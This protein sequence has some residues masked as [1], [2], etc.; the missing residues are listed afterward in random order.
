M[1]EKTVQMYQFVNKLDS[2]CQKHYVY[3]TKHPDMTSSV[4]F[5]RLDV[6]SDMTS[7]VVFSRSGVAPDMKP[8]VLFSR[9]GLAPDMTSRVVFSRSGLAG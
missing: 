7:R 8:R 5:S 1:A 9:S 3:Y 2:L 6:A 4:V